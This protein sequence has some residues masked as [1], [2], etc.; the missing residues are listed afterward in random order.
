MHHMDDCG[1]TV[2]VEPNE[3]RVC[4]LH[5]QQSIFW[6]NASKRGIIQL[7]WPAEMQLFLSRRIEML[8]DSSW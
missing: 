6:L 3:A 4:P 2:T 5:L 1:H 8:T 7:D